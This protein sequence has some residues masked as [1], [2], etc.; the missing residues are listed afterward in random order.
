MWAHYA[1]MKNDEDSQFADSVT[2]GKKVEDWIVGGTK[3]GYKAGAEVF[4]V[5]GCLLKY[6]CTPPGAV[7]LFCF[8]LVC[9]G[10]LKS[11]NFSKL[12]ND[13]QEGIT[14]TGGAAGGLVTGTAATLTS[15]CALFPKQSVCEDLNSKSFGQIRHEAVCSTSPRRFGPQSES[16]C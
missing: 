13:I 14:A 16:M 11:L 7:G 4:S 15:F 1:L 6:P 2:A 5:L 9:R 8:A 12:P 3:I 10:N